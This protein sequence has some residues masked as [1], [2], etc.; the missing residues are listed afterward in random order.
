MW[1]KQLDQTDPL[2]HSCANEGCH[3]CFYNATRFLSF[4][5]KEQLCL[6]PVLCTRSH[7]YW[8]KFVGLALICNKNTDALTSVSV[9]KIFECW[10]AVSNQFRNRNV[11]QVRFLDSVRKKFSVYVVAYVTLFFIKIDNFS[12]MH[13]SAKYYHNSVNHSI[14]RWSCV[15]QSSD[16]QARAF[17]VTQNWSRAAKWWPP[18][19]TKSFTIV[20]NCRYR[21]IKIM[22]CL[23]GD[24]TFTPRSDRETFCQARRAVE[25]Y[26]VDTIVKVS[27]ITSNNSRGCVWKFYIVIL[28]QLFIVII[29]IYIYI[30]RKCWEF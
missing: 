14:S 28:R 27:L 2:I 18:I 21:S 22:L 29:Y 24:L 15:M 9:A 3:C 6:E 17:W 25:I 7:W 10:F 8:I 12:I 1:L 26:I 16:R 5:E 20:N 19:A 30:P 23:F 11:T 4:S 13:C